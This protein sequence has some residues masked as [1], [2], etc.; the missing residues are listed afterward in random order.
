VATYS[1]DPQGIL[2]TEP[3]VLDDGSAL[4]ELVDT[5][6]VP[7]A[8]RAGVSVR[9]EPGPAAV[10]LEL[11]ADELLIDREAC[12][13]AGEP[14]IR[15]LILVQLGGLASVVLEQ[16]RLV[17]AGERW[18]VTATADLALWPRLAAGLRAAVASFEVEP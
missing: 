3:L 16:W 8:S 6:R 1:L 7:G 12:E 11:G 15:T 10:F 14:A 17:A 4:Y 2:E 9:A 13:L 18:V 5:L